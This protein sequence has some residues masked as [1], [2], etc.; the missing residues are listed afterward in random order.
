MQSKV[1][2]RLVSSVITLTYCRKLRFTLKFSPADPLSYFDSTL[3]CQLTNSTSFLNLSP[4]LWAVKQPRVTCIRPY[5]SR[6]CKRTLAVNVIYNTKQ[7]LKQIEIIRFSKNYLASLT[8]FIVI[9]PPKLTNCR[10]QSLFYALYSIFCHKSSTFTI[11]NCVSYQAEM[12]SEGHIYKWSNPVLWKLSINR[13]TP[14]NYQ[15]RIFIRVARQHLISLFEKYL[16]SCDC[17]WHLDYSF[18]VSYLIS[19]PFTWKWRRFGR[20]VMI[21]I[22]ISLK[23]WKVIYR[24]VQKLA[25]LCRQNSPFT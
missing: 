7:T 3:I 20:N 14:M 12:I 2:R 22:L 21:F 16:P 10:K 4:Y 8:S 25:W 19:L 24:D 17:S 1:N 5:N 13:L 18:G 15:E 6:L 9:S 11:T 23:H